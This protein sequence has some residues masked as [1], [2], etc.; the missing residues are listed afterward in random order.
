V[1][2]RPDS[3]ERARA[4]GLEAATSK[5]SFFRESDVISLHLRLVPDTRGIVTREDLELMKP[6][7]ILINSSRAGLVAPNALYEALKAGRPAA[8]GVDVFESEPLGEAG[9]PLLTLP[10]A[11][12][13]PHIGYVTHQEYQLQFTDIFRQITA[14]AAGQPI[15]VVNP[16]VLGQTRSFVQ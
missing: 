11:V 15:N 1:W 16:D 14:Y 4:D 10:N 7:S 8:A 13:T 2:A 3:M 5:E 12:C 6:T 9:H